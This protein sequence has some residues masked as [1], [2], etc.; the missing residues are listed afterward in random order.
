MWSVTQRQLKDQGIPS[1]GRLIIYSLHAVVIYHKKCCFRRMLL[2][3]SRLQ[4]IPE[5]I[6]VQMFVEAVRNNFF[7]DDSFIYLLVKFRFFSAMV[8]LMP[9]WNWWY[10]WLVNLH[11]NNACNKWTYRIQYLFFKINV[12]VGSRSHALVSALPRIALTSTFIV[13]RKLRNESP[14]VKRNIHG[15][16]CLKVISYLS[17]YLIVAT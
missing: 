10:L 12:V 1:S 4:R 2:S 15:Q 7:Q 14:L 9:L 16:R 13:C 6:F 3:V 5:Q 8:S 11:I 17:P